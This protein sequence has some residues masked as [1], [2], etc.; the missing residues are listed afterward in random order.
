ML[1]LTRRDLLKLS[2]AGVGVSLSG[3]LPTLAVRAAEA[4]QRTKSCILLW[5]DGGPSH[6]DTFDL[7]PESKGAGEFKPIKTAAAGV[8][9]SEHLPKVAAVMNHGVVV[10][11]MTTPEGA[12]ARAK[13]YLHTGFREGQGGVI[14]P[15]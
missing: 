12:H 14:Y 8:E 15:S 9:I 5:M 4:R 11:G 7:K 3:W 10:R 1:N 2:A 6:K 13:Y